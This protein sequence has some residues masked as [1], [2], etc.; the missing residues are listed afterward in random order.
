MRILEIVSFMKILE[1][2]SGFQCRYDI[3]WVKNVIKS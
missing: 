1:E 3:F 2:K